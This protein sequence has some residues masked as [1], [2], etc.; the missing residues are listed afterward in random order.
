MGRQNQN[1]MNKNLFNTKNFF[2]L[3][4]CVQL[5]ACSIHT[6]FEHWPADIPHRKLFVDAFN[7]QQAANNAHE[8]LASHLRWIKRFYH[9][10]VVYPMGWNRMTEILLNMVEPAEQHEKIK[11]RMHELGIRIS[12]E[13]A[14]DNSVRK[15]NSMAVATWGDAL[16]TASE[17]NQQSKFITKVEQDVEALI[18]DRLELKQ[19]KRE[20]YYPPEDYDNF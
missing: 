5:A 16:R 20:R 14:Q 15:I 13:W 11:T 10:T 3:M 2:L 18:N 9:G 19:I 6:D 12:I 8:N 17:L 7:R 1:T 4:L